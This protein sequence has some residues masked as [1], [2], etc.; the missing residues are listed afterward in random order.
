MANPSAFELDILGIENHLT[1]SDR[2]A[3]ATEEDAFA[4]RLRRLGGV[5]YRYRYGVRHGELLDDEIHTWLGWPEDR[6]HK[7]GVWVLKLK[8]NEMRGPFENRMTG[9]IRLAGTMPDRC[10]AI[11][12]CGGTFHARPTDE[13]LVPL[14]PMPAPIPWDFVQR[15]FLRP[16][17]DPQLREHNNDE[18]PV[19]GGC[20]CE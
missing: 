14:E 3:D 19:I 15:Y 5:F 12:M 2:S 20:G 16:L 7:G 9:R 4:L 18:S 10:R 6:E 17:T 8:R 1:E 13:H 11:E